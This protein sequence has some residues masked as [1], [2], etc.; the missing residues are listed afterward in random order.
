[1]LFPMPFVCFTPRINLSVDGGSS[2]RAESHLEGRGGDTGTPGKTQGNRVRVTGS[3][4]QIPFGLA[5]KFER[6][7]DLK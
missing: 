3:L 1:M 2:L 4:M 6:I 7:S 5:I